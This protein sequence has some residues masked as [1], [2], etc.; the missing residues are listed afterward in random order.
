MG[1]MSSGGSWIGSVSG[2]TVTSVSVVSANGLNGTVATPTTTPAITLST[3]IT[4]ILKG[5]G[6]AI[7]SAVSGTDYQAPLSFTNSIFN[8]SGII[9]LVNDSASPSASKYY[10]TDGSA[11]LGYHSLPS[12]TSGNLT[13][14]STDGIT[15]TNGTG[16]VLGSGTSIAQAQSSAS[17]NGYLSSTDWSTF[18]GK[19]AAITG[20]ASS[21]TSTNL[22]IN[23][24]LISDGFGKIAV[25]TATST[26]LSYLDATSSIQTQLNSKQSAL[27]FSDSLVNT[28][29]TVT[30]VG[31]SVTPG[32]S[33]YYG[34]NGSSTLGY[35]ALPTGTITSVGLSDGST[36]PIYNIGGSPITSSGTLSFTLKN[37]NAR[38]VLAGPSSG[39]PAQPTFRS[40]VSTDLPQAA[41][42]Y[43]AVATTANLAA[44]YANGTAGVGATLTN[45]GTLAALS[46]D[47]IAV[48][49]GQLVLVWQQSSS[50]QNGIYTV[51]NAG[52]ASVAWVLTRSGVFDNSGAG[53]I[54]QGAL[55]TIVSGTLYSGSLFI[56]TGA[57]PFTVGT[58]PISFESNSAGLAPAY[59][60]LANNTSSTAPAVGISS[61]MF[62]GAPSITDTGILFQQTGSAT[63][64]IQNLLQ[65]TNSGS[66]ASADF[67]I[68]NNLG[69]ASTYYANLGINSSNYSG[70][71]SLNIANASY[72]TATSGDLVLGTTTSNIIRFVTNSQTTDALT[73]NTSNASTYGGQ[74]LWATGLGAITHILGPTDQPLAILSGVAASAGSVGRAITVT[75]S[76]GVNT[77]TGSGA[78]SGAITLQAGAGG[79]TTYAT[80]SATGGNASNISLLGGIGGAATGSGTSLTN[81]GG[82][83]SSIAINSGAGAAASNATGGSSFNFAGSGGNITI[84]A[85]N[86]GNAT[87]TGSS[88]TAGSGG[89]I[90]LTAGSNGIATGS[91]NYFGNNGTVTISGGATSGGVNGGGVSINGG[92][93]FVGGSIANGGAITLTAGA[94]SGNVSIIASSSGTAQQTGGT[95]TFTAG[96]G[97]QAGS[98]G[99]F[100]F[101]ASSV[102]NYTS[103]SS[104]KTMGNGSSLTF[105]GAAGGTITTGSTSAVA[106]IGGNG[107]SSTWTLGNGGSVTTISTSTNTGGSGGGYS[108][109]TGNGANASGGATNTGGNGGSFSVVLGTAGTGATANGTAGQFS[110]TQT[111]SGSD[112][113]PAILLSPTWNT[114]GSPTAIL[115][116]VTNTASGAT[117]KLLDLQ[118]NGSSKFNI[119]KAGNATSIGNLTLNGYISTSLVSANSNFYVSGSTTTTTGS[120]A[121]LGIF[122]SNSVVY[123]TTF[124]GSSVSALVANCNYYNVGFLIPNT[125]TTAAVGVQAMVSNVAI[126][127]APTVTLAGSATVTNTASLYI[128]GAGSTSG[129]SNYAAYVN[130][131]NSYFGGQIIAALNYGLTVKSG[132]TSAKS[133]T[134]TLGGGGTVVVPCTATTPNSAIFV[135]VIVPSGVVGAPYVSAIT[136]STNFTIKST[137]PADTSTIAYVIVE[138]S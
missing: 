109:T 23:R 121:A 124:Y 105:T 61:N 88:A 99:N 66:S 7:S 50:F 85:A 51:T 27:T 71:G 132:S 4:G 76:A 107:S 131:G 135:T 93:G 130:S 35:Y 9:S 64:Y 38:V 41:N 19:Q 1:L 8:S 100:A 118:T 2:G 81:T 13:D 68:N 59:T 24:A 14:S 42:L 54:Y 15:V 55:V 40:L 17:Q 108:V 10:G 16:A 49:V 91:N 52:S 133:G 106:F 47:G 84:L 117:A 138:L 78:V 53:P 126:K 116:N 122:G 114:T 86:G 25:S 111:L 5:N 74:I 115:L 97:Y 18:N 73:I 37:Q 89:N 28:S 127:A 95:I 83:G 6:T 104:A 102:P 119:D 3:T 11:T 58:T 22:T 103:T 75:T 45:S 137:N 34:T 21:V 30:L 57:G 110:I 29:G 12:I 32:A 125:I 39:S 26:A 123:R 48:S 101:T 120:S 90:T 134:A 67:V 72:L 96:A 92:A 33:M 77:S 136:V 31:D 94:I 44:T 63:S 46:I 43:A 69:T 129:A 79:G 113:T 87:G 70:S 60:I 20:A 98:A 56:Q 36:S 112:A 82:N 62:L 65:N 128:D 80:T